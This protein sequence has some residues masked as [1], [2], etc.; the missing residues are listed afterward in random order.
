MIPGSRLLTSF[1]SI[2]SLAGFLAVG[3]LSATANAGA[4]RVSE[5]GRRAVSPEIAVGADGAINVIWLDK[6]LTANRPAPKK[7]APGEHS[8]RSATNLYFARSEDRGRTWSAPTR[9]NHS[10]GEVWGFD[11]SKPRIKVGPTGTIHVFYP[12]NDRSSKTGLDVVSA[13][14]TR[15]TNNGESFSAPITL[16]APAEA[17]RRELLGEGLGM[18]HSF[19]TMGVAPDGTVIAAWQDVSEMKRSLDGADGV[20]AISRDDGAS[21]ESE[22]I[23]L[24]DNKVC[25]CCQLTLAFGE[26]SVYMGYRRIYADGRDSTVARSFDGGRTFEGESR[27]DLA[28]WE[29]NGCPLKPTELAV[30]GDNVYAATYTAGE[31]PAALYFSHSTDAGRSFTGS[32][33]VHPDAPYS[34]APELTVDGAGSV[35]LVWHAKVG[36]PRRLFTAVSMDGGETLS[37]A[38]ELATPPGTSAFPATAVAPDGTVY[39]VWQQQGEEVYVTALAAPRPAMAQE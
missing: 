10:D 21:F 18:T 28:R 37:A 5:E 8:H 22:R 11:V 4:L 27:L 14:Y 7:R 3:L 16:N 6:G 31:Q 19:G 12:A 34:D 33:Q 25:P 24:P 39:V 13:R 1:A 23:V 17:D 35:R 36:G 30:D 20:V 15:S 26:D 29:I 38:K 32:R 2:V 9:V